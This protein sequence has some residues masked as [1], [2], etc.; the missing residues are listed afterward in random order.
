MRP[1]RVV[2]AAMAAVLI[3]AGSLVAQGAVAIAATGVTTAELLEPTCRIIDDAAAANHLPAGFLTR[4]LWQ[5]SRFRNDARSPAGAEGVA[6]FMPRTAS[7]RGL[8]DPRDPAPSIAEAARFL[9]ELGHRLGNLGLAAAAYNAGPG[10]VAR[11]LRRQSDL[12]AETRLYV[13]A[14]TGRSVEDW[15]YSASLQRLPGGE[16][17]PCLVVMTELTRSAPGRAADRRLQMLDR[18]LARATGLLRDLPAQTPRPAPEPPR[19][20]ESLR[21]AEALC[22]SVRSL[23]APCSVYRP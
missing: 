13:A 1:P 19:A 17:E 8:A 21:A 7:L 14:V 3:A 22:A 23:G 4:I 6:Q 15:A 18:A 9:S 5:E 2:T 12:P 16:G 11:W 20:S 10:R